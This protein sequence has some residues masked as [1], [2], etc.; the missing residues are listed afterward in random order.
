M[1]SCYLNLSL[2]RI[3]FEFQSFL[4]LLS[5]VC[6]SLYFLVI[7][8]ILSSFLTYSYVS[9][10]LHE[11]L[12]HTNDFNT[13]CNVFKQFY[14]YAFDFYTTL[15]WQTI[16]SE[17]TFQ[18]VKVSISTVFF[19]NLSPY[20]ND[21]VCFVFLILEEYSLVVKTALMGML[22]QQFLAS[23]STFLMPYIY[24]PSTGNDMSLRHILLE[25]SLKKIEI[26]DLNVRVFIPILTFLSQDY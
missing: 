21:N 19:Y 18:K 11:N 12:L 16:V 14:I 23:P 26:G 24:I 4:H 10:Q 22:S 9:F 3:E 2:G 6:L 20:T 13:V 25:K 8:C 5:T 15:F 1:V 7:I 17:A